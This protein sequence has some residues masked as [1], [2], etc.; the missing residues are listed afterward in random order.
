MNS[1]ACDDG[2]RRARA[3]LLLAIPQ[4]AF[5]F[6]RPALLL[7]RAFLLLRRACLS[8]HQV[9]NSF[10]KS[11]PSTFPYKSGSSPTSCRLTSTSSSNFHLLV[12]LGGGLLQ[13]PPLR[14]IVQ[15]PTSQSSLHLIVFQFTS[16]P[17]PWPP[18]TESQ[19]HLT[20]YLGTL[21]R[22]ATL[23]LHLLSYRHIY[24]F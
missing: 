15:T 11:H 13:Q 23:Y 3:F 10:P 17:A 18:R 6:R 22:K 21:V 24:R 9:C 5:L 8:L 19:P 1:S 7:R 4:C 20:A 12:H 16:S 14:P 2:A